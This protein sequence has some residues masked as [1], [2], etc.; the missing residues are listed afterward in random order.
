MKPEELNEIRADLEAITPWPWEKVD[1][2]FIHGDEPDAHVAINGKPTEIF[3]QPDARFIAKA[4]ERISALLEEI[5]RLTG[6][7]QRANKNHEHFE[8]EWYLA[9][10]ERDEYKAKA[11]A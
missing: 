11:A 6:C 5:E 2:W 1:Y 4:P 3:T 10:D 7:L 8:R 9:C